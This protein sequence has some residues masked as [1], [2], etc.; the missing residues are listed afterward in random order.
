M[1]AQFSDPDAPNRAALVGELTVPDCGIATT[2][3]PI[4]RG[5]RPSITRRLATSPSVSEGM[6]LEGT[7]GSSDYDAMALLDL[8]AGQ[9]ASQPSAERQG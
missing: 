8:A 1:A 9:P 2:S 3:K 6:P 5:P 7:P 4:S